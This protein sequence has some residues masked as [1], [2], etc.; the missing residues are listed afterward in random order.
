MSAYGPMPSF[1]V[2][3]GIYEH[4]WVSREYGAADQ[5]HLLHGWVVR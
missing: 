3:D 2:K 1:S 5:G 4:V